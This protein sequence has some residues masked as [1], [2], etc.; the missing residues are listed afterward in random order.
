LA[1]VAGALLVASV[2]TASLVAFFSSFLA[3][4]GAAA[5]AVTAGAAAGAL[6]ASAAK[7]EVATTVAIRAINCFMVISFDLK[8]VS[9]IIPPTY[10]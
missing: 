10:I 7:V 9:K 6:G 5:G 8:L 4:A 2:L 1:A 3:G